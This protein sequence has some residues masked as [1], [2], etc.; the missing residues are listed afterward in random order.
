MRLNILLIT[1]FALVFPG[2]GMTLALAAEAKVA[3]TELKHWS[4]PDYTRVAIT[5][6]KE[7]QYEY[8][9]IPGRLYIDIS[10]AHLSPG[11]KDLTVGDGLLKSVRVAQYRASIV[12]VVLDLGSIKD[13]KIFTFSD[14][15]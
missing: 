6:D 12:R 10:G 2:F 15:F 14:P 11:V 3:V 13:S 1:L 9:K 8:H 5:L 7:T 4:T